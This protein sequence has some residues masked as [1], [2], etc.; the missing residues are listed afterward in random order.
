MF[1]NKK[2]YRGTVRQ[3][4]HLN[5]FPFDSQTIRIRFGMTLYGADDVL[6][7]NRTDSEVVASFDEHVVQFLLF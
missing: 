6:L 1:K 2:R 4:L 5:R 3:E 7:C